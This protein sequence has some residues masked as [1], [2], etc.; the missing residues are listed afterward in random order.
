MTAATCYLFVQYHLAV[1]WLFPSYA[2]RMV[3][4]E[5]NAGQS[6]CLSPEGSFSTIP[7]KCFGSKRFDGLKVVMVNFF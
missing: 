7:E 5:Y 2:L 6:L 4:A 1:L 3:L